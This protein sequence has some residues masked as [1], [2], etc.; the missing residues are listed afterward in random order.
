M[1]HQA[2]LQLTA[3]VTGALVM[4]LEIV[5]F[6]LFAP[7]FG[8]SIFVSGPLIGIILSALALGSYLGG[9]IVDRLPTKELL[10]KIL[11][12]ADI[13]LF[14]VTF[15]HRPLLARLS[16]SSQVVGTFAASVLLFVP[17]MLT[18]GVVLPFLV[19]LTR[20]TDR[21]G[22]TVGKL[23]ATSTS[24]SII[25][26][27]AAT[28]LLIP[29]LGSAATLYLCAAILLFLALTPLIVTTRIYS[30]FLMLLLLF[31]IAEH[32]NDVIFSRESAYNQVRVIE[33]ED[34]YLLVVNSERWVQSVFNKRGQAQTGHFYDFMNIAPMLADGRDM[35]V[36]GLAGGTSARQ[37]ISYFNARVDGVEID[38]VVIEAAH[39][40]FG[41]P[42]EDS[43]LTIYIEDARPFL[44][45]C[46]KKYDVI[47]LDVYQGGA[48]A[49]FHVVTAEFFRSI[50]EH[51]NGEGVLIMNVF[52]PRNFD[53][54]GTLVR[55]IGATMGAV[56]PSVFTLPL[57][58]NNLLIARARPTTLA[59]VKARLARHMA[60]P[61]PLP[62]LAAYGSRH[63][64]P[65]APS[66]VVLTDDRSPIEL[67]TYR[68]I[69]R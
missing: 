36:L 41:L 55:S 40:F 42:S 57:G 51:L 8:Y 19:K 33:T 30:A 49:P 54:E 53:R 45:R 3:F 31:P 65:Y 1:S 14:A 39:R 63:I 34:Q 32:R 21:L 5:G 58:A 22:I 12:G 6:R 28:F 2:Y 38:P 60:D 44:R 10:F 48:Y 7:Y 29:T 59:D 66:G 13:Y 62:F 56:Y 50:M 64:Q 4:I 52:A 26:T 68:T 20:P 25:G 37:F 16:T 24:G 11:L 35:L 61:A 23:A 18:L 15:W 27:F 17:P 47:D 43:R 69:R 46:D 9:A 67:I